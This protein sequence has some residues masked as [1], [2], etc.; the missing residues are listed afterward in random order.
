MAQQRVRSMR[1]GKKP[2]EPMFESV[3]ELYKELKE[4]KTLLKK[5]IKAQKDR[6]THALE[7][8]KLVR[9]FALITFNQTN[10]LTTHPRPP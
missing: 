3:N 2:S 8:A 5:V 9:V 4:V 7:L 10:H 6:N 1:T